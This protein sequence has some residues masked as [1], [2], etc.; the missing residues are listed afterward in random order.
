MTA[1]TNGLADTSTRVAL[2]WENNPSYTSYQIQ[3]ATDAA[4]ADIM[5]TAT[6]FENGYTPIGLDNETTYFWRVKPFNACGE[7]D[8]STP[9]SFTTIGFTCEIKSALD[10]PLEISGIGTPTV[11]SKITFSEDLSVADINVNLDIDHDY[12]EDLTV[13][14]TSPSKV[15]VILISNSCGN[16]R[17]MNATFDDDAPDFVCGDD[18]DTAIT[19][20]VK[21][22][23]VLAS[24]KGEST[25]GEWVLEIKDNVAN[26]GGFLNGFSLD[27]CV[28]GE[29]RPD[30]DNDGVFDDGDDLCPDTPPGAEVDTSGCPIFRFP[31]D[32]FS[33]A[34]QSESCRDNNDGAITVDAALTFDIEYDIKV[35]GD[36]TSISD[37]FVNTFTAP[38]LAA[39]TY[40]VC[41]D[42]LT[43]E[44]D[45][46]E[47][48]FEV[49]VTQPEPLGVTSQLSPDGTEILLSMQ[50]ADVYTIALN[51][52]TVRTDTSQISLDLNAGTNV[53]K[54]STDRSCQGVFENRF[55]ISERPAVF[56]NPFDK[57][58]R[59]FLGAVEEKVTIAIFSAD[60]QLVKEGLYAPDGNVVDLDFTGCPPGV[61]VVK[62]EG[63]NTSGTTKVI[64]R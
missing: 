44:I 17:N 24:F 22:L 41:I 9:F 46:E 8:F 4:F 52:K 53:L 60:G 16:L 25:L 28:E 19:G 63:E 18:P 34:V 27:I 64:K 54:V 57:F 51:G 5:E 10:V 38:G 6:V 26:D 23:G 62:F 58:T 3:I 39:G 14:L 32:N 13:S 47:Y 30:T 21:P 20:T 40:T 59:L 1:P 49:T 61:Y 56:P 2:T 35:T 43:A 42:G 31:N 29:F 11:I 55:V 15:T 48:C 50:G 33:V 45:Y 12:I 37:S 7:G 36:N